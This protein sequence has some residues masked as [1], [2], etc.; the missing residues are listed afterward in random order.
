MDSERLKE[1]LLHVAKNIKPNTQLDDVYDQLALLADIDE[2]EE[3]E[4]MEIVVSHEEVIST[5]NR[6]I[7]GKLHEDFGQG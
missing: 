3:Q 5:M 1:Y 6:L 2:S 4:K 7:K